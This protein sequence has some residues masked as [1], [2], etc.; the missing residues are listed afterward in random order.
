LDIGVAVK[1]VG[2]TNDG[3]PGAVTLSNVA[4]HNLVLS[5]ELTVSPRYSVP[6]MLTVVLPTKVQLLPSAE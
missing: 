4:V 6:V 2:P 3:Q 5:R 1:F